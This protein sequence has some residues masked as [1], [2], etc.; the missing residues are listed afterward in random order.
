MKK[1]IIAAI[2]GISCM[3]SGALAGERVGDAALGALSGAVVFGPVGA[4]AGAAVGYTAGPA[5]ARSW[6]LGR[7]GPRYPRR[8]VRPPANISR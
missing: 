7:S 8:P 4:I 3:P 6:G 5:I 2:I 1:I